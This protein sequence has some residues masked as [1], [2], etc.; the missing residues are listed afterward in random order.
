M[1]FQFYCPQGHLLQG[2]ES[3]QGQQSQCPMCG[4]VFLIPVLAP[5]AAQAVMT[6]AVEAPAP[7]QQV[8]PEPPP[9]PEPPPPEPEP[10]RIVHIPC[11]NGHAL[12]TPSDM[13][14][15]QALCPYC[16]AQ[17]ELRYEDSTEYAEE[18]AEKRRL[19][20]EKFNKSLLKWAI[21]VA[22]LVGLTVAGMIGYQVYIAL[23]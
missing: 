7:P 2:D 1:P 15:Q 4:T 5:Q 13:F 19:K 12:E 16:N 22:V 23:S 9:E 17:F 8:A 11:P 14:G 20:E 18:K 10:P 3:Q 21:R 6:P